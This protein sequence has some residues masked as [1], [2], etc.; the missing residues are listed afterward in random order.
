M[1]PNPGP[2]CP[3][4]RIAIGSSLV[5][6]NSRSRSRR[7]HWR[8]EQWPAAVCRSCCCRACEP[9]HSLHL[10][11]NDRTAQSFLKHRSVIICAELASIS[12]S[13]IVWCPRANQ[14][15]ARLARLTARCFGAFWSSGGLHAF[16]AS[17]RHY[18]HYV[19]GHRSGATRIRLRGGQ[20]I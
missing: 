10:P 16:A 19:C 6:R 11:L 18:R 4:P 7:R 17:L 8:S 5:E 13:S 15:R 9:Y 2:L 20:L 12:F 14:P 1:L 3:P